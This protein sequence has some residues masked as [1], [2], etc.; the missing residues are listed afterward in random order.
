MSAGV[1]ITDSRILVA[2][3][4]ALGSVF[5]GFLRKG[6]LD[7]TLLG[8]RPHLDAVQQNGLRIDGLWGEHEVRDFGIAREAAE[9]G[10][11]FDAVV[12]TVKSYDT[13][14]IVSLVTPLL[15]PDG[16]MISLQNGL[17]N[18]ETIEA[19]AGAPRS[20]GARVIFGALI[21]EPGRVRVTVFADPT[22]I[23]A[24]RT[25]EI[26]ERDTKARRWAEVIDECGVP[27]CYTECLET[28]LWAK[29]FYNAA[30]NPLGALL[31]VHYGRLPENRDSRALMDAV[32]DEA[33][34]VARAEGV[35][36]PWDDPEEYR[37]EFYDRLVPATYDHRSSMLQD[38]ERGRPTEVEAI[39]GEI[40]RRGAAHGIATPVNETLT[41][42]IRLVSSEGERAP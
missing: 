9:L 24:L 1:A 18:L 27:S 38:L 35:D 40:C 34:A 7:V 2:G 23:G 30:L 21:P 15:S 25:G 8:R 22:A 5:G 14:R 10:G 39:S 37:R 42:M 3:A 36:L 32:I 29:V 26:P 20:I 13:Q 33:D 17:G 6:G 12:V 28:L 31:R 11:H 4:G 19:I 41:R 16:V